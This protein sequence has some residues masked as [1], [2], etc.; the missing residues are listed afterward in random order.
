MPNGTTYTFKINADANQAKNELKSLQTSIENVVTQKYSANPLKGFTEEA[1]KAASEIA[2]LNSELQKSTNANGS[3]N[4][5]K[6]ATLW[7]E[8]GKSLD[9]YK[10]H[11]KTLGPEGE[12]AFQQL[13]SSI[14]NAQKPLRELDGLVGKFTKGLLNTAMWTVQSSAIHAFQSAL[15]GAFGYAQQLNKGLTDIAIVADMSSEKLAKFAMDANKY[16][17]QWSTTTNEYVKGA[18]IYYQQGLSGEEVIEKTN[19]TVKLANTSGESAEQISSYMTAIWNNFDNGS[20]SVEYYADVISYLG[21][22][23]AASNADI[24]EGMQAFA[25]TANTVGLS[26]EYAASALTTLRHVTQQSASTIGNSLKTIFARL[27]SLKSGDTTE[28]G[29]D[30]TKYTKELATYGVNVRD[31]NGELKD[32]DEILDDLAERWKTLSNTQKVALAQTVGGVRQYNNLISLMDNYEYFQKLVQGSYDSGGYLDKQAKVF[33][34]SWQGATNHIRASIEK[35]YNILIDDKFIIRMTNLFAKIIDIVGTIIEKAGGLKTLLPLLISYITVGIRDKINDISTRMKELVDTTFRWKQIMEAVTALRADAVEK[36]VEASI[37]GPKN[38]NNQAQFNILKNQF[39]QNLIEFKELI[40]NGAPQE[41]VQKLALI[42]DRDAVA[43]NDF[44]KKQNEID[45]ALK[46]LGEAKKN[47][48]PYIEGSAK[49][50]NLYDFL[51]SNK[52]LTYS[53]IDNAISSSQIS[54]ES[55]K[56]LEGW[57]EF[58]TALSSIK[59]NTNKNGGKSG[60]GTFNGQSFKNIEELRQLI[61]EHI[62]NYFSSLE[63]TLDKLVKEEANKVSKNGKTKNS[64]T[65]TST[66]KSNEKEVKEE[67]KVA[68]AR[69]DS[70]NAANIEAQAQKELAN[71]AENLTDKESIVATGE[72]ALGNSMDHTREK[73]DDVKTAMAA[74]RTELANQ[75]NSIVGV[76]NAFL[77]LQNSMSSMLDGFGE[78]FNG[79]IEEGFKKIGSSLLM[80]LTAVSQYSRSLKMLSD[81]NPKLAESFT[82][83]AN[84]T[85]FAGKAFNKLTLG[86]FAT[87]TAEKDAGAAATTMGG[88]QVGAAAG[89]ATM[90]TAE[91]AATV[92]T[93]TL[94]GAI[95]SF[96]TTAGGAILVMAG[97]ALVV[98][99]VVGAFNLIKDNTWGKLDSLKEKAE[100]AAEAAEKAQDDYDTLITTLESLDSKK[101]E[102]L[103]LGE[104]E[105]YKWKD[106]L[107]RVND[108]YDNIIKKLHLIYGV[109]WNYNQTTGFIE[110]T[111]EEDVKNRY[112][113]KAEDTAAES[114]FADLQVAREAYNRGFTNKYEYKAEPTTS[115]QDD[116]GS[117]TGSNTTGAYTVTTEKIAPSFDSAEFLDYKNQII[118]MIQE[119]MNTEG[120]STD[121]LNATAEEL[122]QDTVFNALKNPEE[123]QQW[124]DDHLQAIID[125]TIENNKIPEEDIFEKVDLDKTYRL[126]GAEEDLNNEGNNFSKKEKTAIEGYAKELQS[127]PDMYGDLVSEGTLEAEGSVKKLAIAYKQAKDAIESWTKSW[128]DWNDAIQEGDELSTEFIDAMYEMKAACA[129]Y[130]GMTDELTA[131]DMALGDHFGDWAKEHMDTVY[132]ALS[133]SQEAALEMQRVAAEDI[134]QQLGEAKELT[135][136]QLNYLQQDVSSF[137]DVIQANLDSGDLKFGKI[138]DEEFLASLEAMVNELGLSV[139]E[140]EALA[141]AMGIDAEFDTNYDTNDIVDKYWV[142]AKYT[143]GPILTTGTDGESSFHTIQVAEGGEGRWEE[144]PSQVATAVPTLK[145]KTADYVGGGNFTTRKTGSPHVGGNRTP[146]SSGG[147]GGHHRTPKAKDEDRYHEINQKLKQTQHELNKVNVLKDRSYGRGRLKAMDEEIKLLEREAEQYKEMYKEAEHWFSIDKAALIRYGATFNPD[148]TIADYQAWQES[149]IDK[150]NNESISEEE[151]SAWQKAVSHF[152]DSLQHLNEA[153]EKY[154]TAINKKYDEHLEKVVYRVQYLNELIEL[155]TDYLDYLIDKLDED[156]YDTAETVAKM[157][158]KASKILEQISN[159]QDG[160]FDA[161]TDKNNH[162]KLNEHK[163]II[164]E[165]LKGTRDLQD[166]LNNIGQLTDKEQEQLRKW[167]EQLI[168]YNKELRKTQKEA[169]DKIIESIEE[170]NDKMERQQDIVNDTAGVMEHYANIIDIIG[171]DTLGISDAMMN[172]LNDLQVTAAQSNLTIALTALNENRD[173]L[174][175]IQ[176]DLAEARKQQAETDD[177]LRKRALENDIKYL[178]EAMEQQEDIVRDLAEEWASA[179]ED[180]LKSAQDAFTNGVKL[181]TEA[182]DKAVSGSIGSLDKLQDFYDKQTTLQDIFLPDYERIHDLSKLARDINNAI[183]ATDNIK[184]KERLRN[185]QNEILE[186]QREGTEL[187]KYDMEFMQK[188]FELEQAQIAME[189]Q[190]NAKNLVRMTRD[191]EGNWSYTYTQNPENVAKAQQEFEDKLY[192]LEKLNQDRVK[193]TQQLMLNAMEK[194]RDEIADA[195][196]NDQEKTQALLDYWRQ[197]QEEYGNLTDT[198]LKNGAWITDTYDVSN[199]ELTDSFEETLLS[200]GTGYQTLEDFMNDFRSASATMGDDVAAQY[201]KWGDYVKAITEAAGINFDNFAQRVAD[202]MDLVIAAMIGEDGNG[203]AVGVAKQLADEMGMSVDDILKELEGWWSGPEGRSILME[204]EIEENE[205]TYEQLEKLIANADQIPIELPK[206]SQAV[207][208]IASGGGNE[209]GCGA[210]CTT[211]CWTDCGSNGASQPRGCGCGSNCSG[212]CKTGCGKSVCEGQCVGGC[213]SACAEHCADGCS[214]SCSYSSAKVGT[215]VA[216]YGYKPPKTGLATGGYTGAWGSW[217]KIAMLHEKELVLNKEDTANMLATVGFV[218]DLVEMLTTNAGISASGFGNLFAGGVDSGGNNY[219]DQNVTIHAEFPNATN[220]N[221]IEEAFQNLIGLAGQYAGRKQ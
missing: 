41:A 203:G 140:A 132:A 208:K 45:D 186:A 90:A 141:A 148:G 213:L 112:A 221:E 128:Y 174:A 50:G 7:K 91:G 193:E 66:T 178:E 168:D 109:D 89:A 180:A 179:Y 217:G 81:T 143:Q 113:K 201:Q 38:E 134:A 172:A 197:L 53:D 209:C 154:I 184:G 92:A 34:E 176:K 214:I 84:Q 126:P 23:T 85:G 183:N 192:E 67:K 181:A 31:T 95:A 71:E 59:F 108:E 46:A 194:F 49:V 12:R 125:Q 211:T 160:I 115:S 205:K 3:L 74:H 94:T 100:K 212:G 118:M 56:N 177:E 121:V 161:L 35:L 219:L 5:A 119:A 117:F 127:S 96:L 191:N 199:H 8:N 30:L 65:N 75:I 206:I 86:L 72:E 39:K 104:K 44:A 170:F 198:A 187:S 82:T 102:L 17:Q 55:G 62:V 116:F 189:E 137:M 207:A 58:Q 22:A 162:P 10:Q 88:A 1:N 98:K 156:M 173:A 169:Y 135:D 43:L 15:S 57:D 185:L 63:G 150:Y 54:T 120:Y 151:F 60:G 36:N 202:D 145:I 144:V 79:N 101:E 142:P 195:D 171:K 106:G 153:E 51:N 33:E 76:A 129:D 93:T 190:R 204:A 64:N 29:I 136:E 165:Y 27:S 25:A 200:L 175:K 164:E 133:G 155:S 103:A 21:A 107:R 83:L 131:N 124:I 110:F 114:N 6:L 105:S 138:N 167:M 158:E 18:L 146:K 37:T 42:L 147:G 216:E 77:A 87:E 163:E 13:A 122:M 139:K 4:I 61:K 80:S 32:M 157:G 2:Q 26:Y 24:A 152:E 20:K 11:F 97:I 99:A 78:I 123:L 210:T 47:F 69:K 40:Q 182:F 188:R 52:K 166:V 196:M 130:L 111:N 159:V 16:A 70:A 149:W 19:T 73:I 215:N 218:R 28:D 14:A 220:H 48:V 68:E 9:Y